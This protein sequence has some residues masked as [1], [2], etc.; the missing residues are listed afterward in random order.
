MVG[1]TQGGYEVRQGRVATTR[2]ARRSICGLR[3]GLISMPFCVGALRNSREPSDHAAQQANGR[4]SENAASV[5][6]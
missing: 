2:T 1:E 5:L 4:T 6:M 3:P